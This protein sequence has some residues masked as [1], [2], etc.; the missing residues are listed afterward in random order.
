MY[1]KIISVFI[2][3]AL[4][5]SQTAALAGAENMNNTEEAIYESEPAERKVIASE[6]FSEGMENWEI[7]EGTGYS[8]YNGKLIFNNKKQSEKSSSLISKELAVDNGEV[9]FDFS[10]QDGDYFG[11]IFRMQDDNTMYN[12]R[13]YY[14]SDKVMLLKKVKGG[15]FISLSKVSVPLEYK[16]D[17]K[18]RITLIG[19]RIEVRLDGTP[20]ISAEDSSIKSG[21]IG[22]EGYNADASADNIE[23]FKYDNIEYDVMEADENVK[24]TKT[25]Y[26]S[27]LGNN[28]T[29]D[30][31]EQHPFADI[32]AAKEAVKKAKKGNTPVDV[33]FKEGRYP[34]EQTI[35]F[36]AA[37]SGT[38]NAPV[39]YMAE[40]GAKVVFTGASKLDVTKF[41]PVSGKMQDRIHKNAK[42]KVLQMDLAG[43]GIKKELA[44]FTAIYE[45]GQMGQNLKPLIF[46]LNGVQQSIARWPNVG[47]NLITASE[48]GDNAR[49]GGKKENA[50]TIYYTESDPSRWVNAER[51]YIE[52]FL[53]NFWHGEWAKVKNIDTDNNAINMQYYTQYGIANNHRWAA[54]NLVEEI[55][56]PGE[57]YI[58][59]DEMMLYYY[60]P[61]EL[62]E[63]D[64]FEVA[65]LA[66]NMV[67]VLGAS[68]ITF[69]GI[70]FTMTADDPS[71]NGVNDTG[72][73][74]INIGNGS[75]FIT[76]KDCVIDHIGMHGININST[77]VTI[78]GCVI[79]DIGF[80]GINCGNTGDR[81]TLAPSNVV[82]KNC[83]ISDVC[84]DT[85]SNGC[86]GIIMQTNT[87]DVVVT[88][89]IIHNCKN[90]VIRYSGNGHQITYNEFYNA[91]TQTADAGAIYA[92]RSWAEYGTAVKYNFFHDI[93]Q[94]K[95]DGNYPAS[96]IFWDDF[97]SGGEF[98]YNI[99]AVNNYTKTSTVKIGGGIDNIVKGN[100]MISSENDIIGEDRSASQARDWPSYAN[101][102]LKYNSVPVSSDVFSKKYPKMGTI[103]QR[104]EE[105]NNSLKLENVITDNLTVDCQSTRIAKSIIEASEYERNVTIEDDY[106]IF[107]DPENLD[108][109]VKKSAKEKYGISDEILDEDFDIE[110]IGIQNGYELDKTKMEFMATYPVNGQNNIETKEV[111]LAWSKAPLA[112]NY[113]YV[114]AE[115]PEFKNIVAEDVTEFRAVNI[116]N[117]KNAKKYYWKVYAQNNSRQVGCVVEASNG[118]MSFETS[119]TDTLDKSVLNDRIAKAYNLLSNIKEGEGQG[120]YRIG[121]LDSIRAKIAE[122]EKVAAME[123]GSQV[124]IDNM[125]YDM[126]MF[127][128]GIDSFI[129]VGYTTLNLKASS[130]WYTNNKDTKI[131]PLPGSVKIEVG[132]ASEVSLCETL[133]NYNVMCFRTKI[134]SL[135]NTWVAYGLRALDKDTVIYAQDA[136]Y[137][138]VKPDIFEL[139][140]HG[141]IYMTAPNNGKMKA[142]EWYDVQFGAITT[143]KGINMFFSLNGEVIFDYLDTTDPQYKPGMFA[144]FNGMAGN[145]IEIADAVSVP[146]GLYVMSDEIQNQIHAKPDTSKVLKTEGEEYVES[147]TWKDN[148][149]LKGDNASTV[150]SSA[151]ANASAKWMMNA[152][153]EGNTKLFK[154]SYYHIPSENGDKNVKVHL[155]G[156]A[157]EYETTIDLSGGEEGYVDIGTFTFMDADYIGRLSITFTGSG[158]GEVNVSNV[159]YEMVDEKEYENMLK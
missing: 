70:E 91:V 63:K 148:P 27:P 107:V 41:E 84:R 80:N 96:S 9:E 88:N 15:S 30:G 139:Q 56:I 102:T 120:E 54:V 78:D 33:I 21:K 124:D 69:E 109:R 106:D 105:N 123:S 11:M 94:K 150:R 40:E 101:S 13:F 4:V 131:T 60:P 90:S 3:S 34:V 151:E 51:L 74:G 92:G 135:E 82:I 86:G 114:V 113:R 10:V 129:N 58:D 8:I 48:P 24:E 117:L 104:I 97:Q 67:D 130:E 72:G 43:Q 66:T 98:S 49:N 119:L 99:S 87:V 6:D 134:A 118:V 77:D 50:G 17:Y 89:N 75:K 1:K 156:Y 108:Y 127:V 46:T 152:G 47:Y 36:T 141:K 137:I 12:L 73:N 158:E 147:G 128:N 100:T 79:Y 5:I 52:G 142:G 26:V 25:I 64:S 95:N 18:A 83:D 76:V 71:V 154:V 65:T 37:D 157:G 53:A 35:T 14:R 159:K 145:V 103:L 16:K 38:Q 136:Y 111:V 110:S 20:I 126:N 149:A 116:E 44:D 143:E 138:L 85:G 125:A 45:N 153:S 155:S 42:G 59:P 7:K 23:I 146:E 144:M 19:K 133:S 81:Q 29:A 22:F 121:T 132:G 62:T 61:Y 68:N 55:D 140:K 39:R 93:G 115:D 32:T 2:T 57:W 28:E 112:D 122:A 31:S